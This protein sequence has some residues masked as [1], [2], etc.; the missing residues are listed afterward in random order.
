MG[1]FL[2]MTSVV[3]KAT[4]EVLESLQRYVQ[5]NGGGLEEARLSVESNHCCVITEANG[6]PSVFYP[7]DYLEWDRSTEFISRDLQAPAFSFHIHDGDLWMYSLFVNGSVADQFNPIPGYWEDISEAEAQ[8]WSGNA[9]IVAQH[10]RSVSPG[11][12][13]RYLVS[14]EED[15]DESDPAYAGDEFGPE[16]WQLL[17]FTR[18]TG[19]PYP[20]N[21][22]G[23]ASG[24]TYRL[25]TKEL[26][27]DSRE[28]ATGKA[29]A[30][31]KP[32]WKFW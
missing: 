27:R 16:A 14:W 6:N 10:L 8:R 21:E 22:D 24:T 30:A 9:D 17:D 3:G 7:H 15:A 31:R 26:R 13:Q 1:M 29:V 12:I 20:L 4:P 19:L 2:S 28:S 18:K 23:T 11:S 25:W 5:Q 32:W